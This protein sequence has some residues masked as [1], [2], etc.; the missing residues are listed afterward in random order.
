MPESDGLKNLGLEESLA[1]SA[2]TDV[3][4]VVVQKTAKRQISKRWRRAGL[5]LT[6]DPGGGFS[7]FRRISAVDIAVLVE[8]RN[9]FLR[10][11]R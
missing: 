7:G 1:K 9:R 11:R 4:A 2:K 5:P 6:V 3:V 8:R 10:E